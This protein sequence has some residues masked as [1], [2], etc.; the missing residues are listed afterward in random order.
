MQVDVDTL[1][2]SP[3]SSDH[4][5]NAGRQVF[6]ERTDADSKARAFRHF[7]H[8]ITQS[9]EGQNSMLLYDVSSSDAVATMEYLKM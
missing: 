9:N 2:I 3:V 7:V 6:G 8:L 1:N 5:W 4:F